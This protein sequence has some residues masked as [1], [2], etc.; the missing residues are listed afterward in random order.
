[1]NETKHDNVSLTQHSTNYYRPMVTA[2]KR[3]LVRDL[4]H[5]M[6]NVESVA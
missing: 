1:M 3:S 4:Y 5:L 2:D 6:W